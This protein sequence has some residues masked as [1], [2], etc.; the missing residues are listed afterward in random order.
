MFCP[1]TS[2]LVYKKNNKTKKVTCYIPRHHDECLAKLQEDKNTLAIRWHITGCLCDVL[3]E[4]FWTQ[5]TEEGFK[6]NMPEESLNEQF[7]KMP[8]KDKHIYKSD[9]PHPQRKEKVIKQP[10]GWKRK[11]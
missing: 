10:Q 1:T 6:F 3:E 8:E 2:F 9:T 11:F 5:P 4:E 7:N